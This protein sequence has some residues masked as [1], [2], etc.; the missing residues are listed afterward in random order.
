MSTSAAVQ[1][2][3]ATA[4]S[5]HQYD[6]DAEKKINIHS[7]LLVD[8]SSSSSS[9]NASYARPSA[10]LNPTGENPALAV[11]VPE[12]NINGTSLSTSPT[13]T[14]LRPPKSPTV[15]GGGSSNSAWGA[16]FWVTLVEPQ[17]RVS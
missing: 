7:T 8:P 3:T 14:A 9:P 13:T 16:N 17:V 11:S 1:I 12:L 4:T 10:H 5:A 6:R 2:A 15:A